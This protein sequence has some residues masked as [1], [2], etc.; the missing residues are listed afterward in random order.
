MA[1]TI[2]KSK[3]ATCNEKSR[4][5]FNKVHEVGSYIDHSG[6][7][8]CKNCGREIASN[9]H[10]GKLPPHYKND[11]CNKAQWQLFVYAQG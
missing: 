3:I 9:K 5:I 8:K 10:E 11:E 7:Y 2:D 1:I 4:E 6:L